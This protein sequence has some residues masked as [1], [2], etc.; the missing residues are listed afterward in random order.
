MKLNRRQLLGSVAAV[1]TLPGIPNAF[2]A[3]KE[4]SRD[5]VIIGGGLGGLSAA[6]AAVNVNFSRTGT[7]G[8]QN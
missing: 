3:V 8:A 5:L 6:N 2:A 4:E 7:L 1:A